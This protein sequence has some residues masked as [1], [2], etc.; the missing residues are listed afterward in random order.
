MASFTPFAQTPW[1]NNWLSQYF[2]GGAQ[3]S[4]PTELD[5][6]YRRQAEVEG[7]GAQ[8]SATMDAARTAGEDPA[9]G[10][11]L[12]LSARAGARTGA[13]NNYGNFLTN[14]ATG[15]Q[16]FYNTLASHLLNAQ[17]DGCLL[18]TSPSPRD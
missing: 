7:E 11:A 2:G 3:L 5:N 13:A 12:G 6:L 8:R 4:P 18:Y 15:Q 9:L 14:F 16:D 10:A 17:G 1:F